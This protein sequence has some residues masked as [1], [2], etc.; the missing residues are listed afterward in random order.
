[1]TIQPEERVLDWVPK[2]DLLS[3]NYM[4]A[5]LPN[6]ADGRTKDFVRRTKNVFLDQGREGACTGFGGENVMALGPHRLDTA[7][8]EQARQIYYEARRQDEFPG[9]AYEGSSVNGA[10]KAMRVMGLIKDWHWCLSLAEIDHALSYVGAVEA[11][12]PWYSN[13]FT[14]DANGFLHPTG[15][16]VG[17][18]AWAISGRRRMPS[19]RIRYRMENSWGQD[20][21]REGA[22]WLWAED[23]E[24][25]L[26]AGAE[27]ACPTKNV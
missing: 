21:G 6:F 9:E 12:S 20:W 18:H 19:G 7:N 22:A 26:T 17:G 25:L 3:F 23:L 5:D 10:M 1:M 8:N 11:G 27:F 14:P 4:V 16:V 2:P 13:M 24:T 15:S